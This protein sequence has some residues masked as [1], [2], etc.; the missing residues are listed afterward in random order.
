MEGEEVTTVSCATSPSTAP[1]PT[2]TTQVPARMSPPPTASQPMSTTRVPATMSPPP[3]A[4][5]PASTTRALARTSSPTTASQFTSTAPYIHCSTPSFHS[6]SAI[7]SLLSFTK[8][9]PQPPSARSSPPFSISNS[10][11]G[12]WGSTIPLPRSAPHPRSFANTNSSSKEQRVQRSVPSTPSHSFSAT[13]RRLS[14]V[15]RRPFASSPVD[16]PAP[17]HFQQRPSTPLSSTRHAFL[18]PPFRRFED[19]RGRR[20]LTSQWGAFMP[21]LS[22]NS[23]SISHQ[24]QL[25]IQD[26]HSSMSTAPHFLAS[27]HAVHAIPFSHSLA[28]ASSQ[29]PTCIPSKRRNIQPSVLFAPTSPKSSY[30]RHSSFQTPPTRTTAIV[31]S[32]PSNL[33]LKSD[34]YN[35]CLNEVLIP[36]NHT[37]AA[38]RSSSSTLARLSDMKELRDS[39]DDAR[40]VG[41]DEQVAE[42]A[43]GV[44]EGENVNEVP[45]AHSHSIQLTT[46]PDTATGELKTMPA[47]TSAETQRMQPFSAKLQPSSTTLQPSTVVHPST[48]L[49]LSPTAL[50]PSPAAPQFTSRAPYIPCS[51]PNLHQG[52]AM[53][54]PHSIPLPHSFTNMIP[55]PLTHLPS[56]GQRTQRFLSSVPIRFP[57]TGQRRLWKTQTRRFPPL[58]VNSPTTHPFRHQSLNFYSTYPSSITSRSCGDDQLSPKRLPLSITTVNNGSDTSSVFDIAL[59]S[60]LASLYSL[61]QPPA[62]LHPH[63]SPP[64]SPKQRCSSSP[65]SFRQLKNT[66]KE[67]SRTPLSQT[68]LSTERRDCT[69]SDLLMPDSNTLSPFSKTC[70]LYPDTQ[71]KQVQTESL[72]WP[73]VPTID[74][75]RCSLSTS[76]YSPSIANIDEL[77]FFPIRS[78]PY[79]GEQASS[80]SHSRAQSQTAKNFGL[81]SMGTLHP[82]TTTPSTPLTPIQAVHPL[83]PSLPSSCPVGMGTAIAQT[84]IWKIPR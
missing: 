14:R 74:D 26:E 45:S 57:S 33:V 53:P 71:D 13:Q 10:T 83:T 39:K 18:S 19:F 49:R 67:H 82:A 36:P 6:T 50:W 16:S 8:A 30:A 44:M 21:P 12:V 27:T 24:R 58:H 38:H 47:R 61:N 65:P 32:R 79:S 54:L 23:S 48:A 84:G 3:M 5:Q 56:K 55:Q 37:S 52:P 80:Q 69:A 28:S 29:L 7:P 81:T 60:P 59:I 68:A 77:S 42:G 64:V 22:T 35:D 66:R 63:P 34:I 76:P 2:S 4:S 46:A 75:G 40:V 11:P 15:Q 72:P 1:W 25:D 51:T 73:D 78:S 43:E 20:L 62:S 17:S 41:N 70:H 9:I 31:R